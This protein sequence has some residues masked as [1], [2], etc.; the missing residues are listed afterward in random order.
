MEED[1]NEV[2]ELLAQAKRPYVRQL[3]TAELE[4]L[5]AKIATQTP[6]PQPQ[7]ERAEQKQP[8]ATGLDSFKTVPSFQW[9]SAANG[10]IKVYIP[11]TGVGALPKDSVQVSIK[12][13]SVLVIAR[14]SEAG[15]VRFAVPRLHKPVVPESSSWRVFANKI[16]LSLKKEEEAAFWPQLELKEEKKMKT[17]KLD[18]KAD[19]TKGLM[20]MMKNLYEEGDDEMKRMIAKTWCVPLSPSR[21]VTQT[22]N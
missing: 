6:P 4:R 7:E 3:L 20:D 15:G 22:T 14:T 17:P 2:K 12:K 19:P 18:D 16:I 13:G 9:E 10:I 1:L 21:P 5:S 11:I 8:L